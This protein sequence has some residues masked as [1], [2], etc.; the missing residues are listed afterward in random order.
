MCRLCQADEQ[1]LCGRNQAELSTQGTDVS[2]RPQ[3]NADCYVRRGTTIVAHTQFRVV[4][5][6]RGTIFERNGD[7]SIGA[8]DMIINMRSA[9]QGTACIRTVGT[10]EIFTA[11]A[12]VSAGGES[13]STQE[14]VACN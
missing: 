4:S 9:W 14:Q 5:S 1:V 7:Y 12:S 8:D 13:S 10:Y 3:I 11:F 6:N 2:W